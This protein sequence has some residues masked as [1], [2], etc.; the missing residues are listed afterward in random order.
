M[1]KVKSHNNPKTDR[2]HSPASIQY[3]KTSQKVTFPVSVSYRS[4][5]FY[6][7]KHSKQVAFPTSP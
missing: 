7:K 1:E 2:C 6:K 4:H 5:H 3:I